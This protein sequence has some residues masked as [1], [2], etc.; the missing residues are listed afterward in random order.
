MF[1]KYHCIKQHDST[2]CAA[3]CLATICR[4][5]GSKIPITKI[6]EAA[7]SDR[8]GTSAY[9]VVK[10]AEKLD[11][12]AKAIKADAV[13]LYEK[14]PLPCIAHIVTDENMLHYV[15]IHRISKKQTIVADP[16]KGIVKYTP[17]DFL[18]IWTGVLIL[19]VPTQKFA[20]KDQTKGLFSRYFNLLLPHKTLLLNIFFTSIVY[21]ALGILSSFYFKFM[22]DDI[23]PNKLETTLHTLSVGIIL[24]Y[25]IRILLNA[26]RAYML[27]YLSQRLDIPLIL[28][29]YRHVLGLPLAF[30]GSYKVGEIISRF[31]D[32]SNIRQAI[33]S[34]TLT[35]MIDTIMAFAGAVVLYM[36]NSF[37]FGI[38]VFML[39][40]YTGVVYSFNKAIRNVNRE[41][42][43]TNASLTSNLVESLNGVETLKA[44]NA[45]RNASIKTEQKFVKL[46][47]VLFKGGSIA[48]VQSSLVEV[49]TQIGG[50]AILWFGALGI[51]EGEMTIGE[52]L[53]FNALLGFFVEPIQNLIGLQPLIQTAIVASD[54][55][56]EIVDLELERS[57]PKSSKAVPD[58][59]YGDIEF[60]N[61]DFR[62]GSRQLV[63][64]N[65]SMKMKKGQKIA[66]VGASGSGKT[67]LVKLLLNFYSWEKGDILINNINIRDIDLEKLRERIAYVSQ[68]VFLYSETVWENITLGVDY[69]DLTE[70][71]EL[72]KM[73]Q[74][75]E[76]INL[77][78]LRYDTMVDENGA[79]FSGG[80]KQML[81]ITRALLKKPDILILDE[82]TANLDPA[83]EKAIKSSIEK[84]AQ[85]MTVIIIAHRLSTVIWCD[86]IYVL[87]KG[88]FVESG[89]H[90]ELM[91]SKGIYYNLWKDQIAEAI[92]SI[93]EEHAKEDI[94]LLS[95]EMFCEQEFLWEGKTG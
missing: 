69:T 13:T 43:E 21:T 58:S 81:A 60:K 28:G 16:G 26:F 22:M 1:K 75:H 45:E 41:E 56:G 92:G 83:T 64:K 52:L 65:L 87:D 84:I 18:K 42:M 6:R 37:L 10:A 79:N 40:I 17:E 36:Q 33:S 24:L 70:V 3:A 67:T 61:V 35:I 27:Q 19:M 14:F 8:R 55:L 88:E 89:R 57:E 80:Q 71:V 66:L 31:M 54:R 86:E 15:V 63:L 11:F 72:A 2:D 49:V 47:R 73:T 94:C 76:F 91:K 9:G 34:A 59:L 32:A 53:T 7:C 39:L 82:A 23:L 46:L 51:I 38:T 95:D 77:L 5:Y 20:K 74:A 85:N 12:A 68:D 30:F 25:I 62:Y 48:N 90:D 44:F 29:Y 78:P 50:I 93:N 4:Q